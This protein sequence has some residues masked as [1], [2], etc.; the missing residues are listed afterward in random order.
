M[1]KLNPNSETPLYMQIVE[2]TKLAIAKG[3]FRNGDRFPSVRELSRELLVNQATVSKAFKELDRQGII[4]TKPGIGTFISFDDNKIS[5]RIDKMMEKLED[6]FLE[7]RYLGI[8]LD[9][10]ITLYKKSGDLDDSRSNKH[11]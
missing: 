5:K 3:L 1:F 9:E 8:S 10:I 7:A 4:E 6:D 11:K 2:Q